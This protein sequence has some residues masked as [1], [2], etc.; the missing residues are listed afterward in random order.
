MR[1]GGTKPF[2]EESLGGNESHQTAAAM[3]K[4]AS[5]TTPNPR[6][7]T[8][9]TGPWARI[10]RGKPLLHVRHFPHVH[11]A[12]P[13]LRPGIAMIVGLTEGRVQARFNARLLLRRVRQRVAD[14]R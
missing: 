4:D 12:L 14:S 7:N 3:T 1:M 6:A 13:A 11:L 10:S 9:R 5:A 8:P 2:R